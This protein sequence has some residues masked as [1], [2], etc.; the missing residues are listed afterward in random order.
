MGLVLRQ[1]L[2]IIC[3]HMVHDL[4]TQIYKLVVFQAY[5][6]LTSMLRQ[7]MSI[8]YFDAD[9][10]KIDNLLSRIGNKALFSF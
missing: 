9:S 3:C 8:S 5:F 4:S 1:R 2:I 6:S 7:S 10:Y